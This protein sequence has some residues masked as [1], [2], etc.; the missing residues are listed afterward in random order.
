MQLQVLNIEWLRHANMY[1]L[2]SD[3]KY[4]FILNILNIEM[5]LFKCSSL[6]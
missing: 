3:L 1:K 5:F 2:Y 4:S 6:P